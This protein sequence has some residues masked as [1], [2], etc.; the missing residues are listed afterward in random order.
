MSLQILEMQNSLV[1]ES[2]KKRPH[3]HSNLPFCEE[4]TR[5]KRRGEL[6]FMGP[7]EIGVSGCFTEMGGG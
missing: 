7:C 6:V 3:V 1:L 2:N 5:D 4:V